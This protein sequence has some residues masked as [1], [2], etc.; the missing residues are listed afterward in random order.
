MIDVVLDLRRHCIETAIKRCRNAAMT[1]YF[2]SSDY[3]VQL[4]AHIDLLGRALQTLDFGALRRTCPLLGGG[5]REQA[6]LIERPDGGFEILIAG[7]RILP[8]AILQPSSPD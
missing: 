8:P 3:P 2:S 4:E 5:T 7:H 1:C 6:R